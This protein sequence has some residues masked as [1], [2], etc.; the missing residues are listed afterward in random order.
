VIAKQD[1]S[2]V[3]GSV[4][5]DPGNDTLTRRQSFEQ[6]QSGLTLRLTSPITDALLSLGSQAKEAGQ[7]G[8]DRLKALNAVKMLES[9]WAMSGAAGQS[10]AALAKGDLNNAG[11]KIELSVGASKS[12]SSSEYNANTIS[13]SSLNGGGNVTV[14]AT[15]A[16]GASGDL[17]LT[18]SGITG[19]NVT[20]AAAHDLNL[21]AASN[22]SDQKSSNKSSGWS[23]GVHIAI[24]QETGIGVQAS[25]FM[26]SGSENGNTTSYV[27]SRV[28]AKDNLTLSS[29]NDTLLSGAQALGNRITVDAG[30]NL[31]LT[32]L[33]D[34]DNYQSKQ[35][36]ASGGFSFT[37]G[38]MTGSAGL[39]ISKSKVKSEY[40]SVGDQSG[41]FAG[42][43][44]YDIYVGNHTQLNGAVI[45]STAQAA[46]NHLSTG[47]LGWGSID[48]HA[49]YSASSAAMGI[50]GGYNSNNKPGEQ[51]AGSALPALVNLNG[52]ASGTTQSAI[53]AGTIT[54]R[55]ERNQKQDVADLSRDTDNANGSIGKIFDKEKVEN[56][57][58]F[59][60]GVQELAGKVVS[61][62]KAYKLDE[63]AKETSDR[64]LKE[65]PEYASLSNE[66]FN[67][68]VRNDS[69]YKDVA[70]KWGTGGTYSMVASAVAGALGGLSANNMGAAASGAMAP[71]IANAIKKATTSYNA[72]GTEKTNLVANTMAHAVAGAILAEI[73]GGDGAAGAA[74]A[75]GGELIARAIVS[76]MY[77]GVKASDLTESQ[78]QTVSA[79]S[80]LAAGLAGSLAS[81]SSAGISAGARAGKNAAENNAMGC[82]GSNEPMCIGKPDEML[83]TGGGGRGGASAVSKEISGKATR[84]P[85]M[86]PEGAGRNG[87]FREAKRQ[88]GIPVGQNPSNVY[89][90]V[91]KRGNSQPGLIYEFD[92][93]K[94]G[95]GTA[96][97]YIRDD[98][99]G[100]SFGSDNPQ[101]R[102]AH[103]NDPKG[104]H[105]DY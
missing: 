68:L 14:V 18:G 20:L 59:A 75:A 94:S 52:S 37:F 3:G 85:N 24:G 98:A 105:Y 80:Q 8:D 73:S 12:K 69:G 91:D 58:A 17:N 13:G 43:G 95:G 35:Q 27:N 92:V 51:Y 78:K 84:P 23:A 83:F 1:I 86:S 6:K 21:I 74:G 31:T 103:F 29:G 50:S 9:G 55:D 28:N 56:Q 90:N 88:A 104:N 99:G 47:T 4:T 77:P 57:M 22:N 44:G 65:H 10:A 32:S 82:M 71:Y 89:P 93:P 41:L 100:H 97:V 87:A 79:L 53:S 38:S 39:S 102:G 16:N 96:K 101:N 49:S 33:Q 72:D 67:T 7:A 42:D 62:V 54:V 2:L 26:A 34:I 40:A 46:D 48:N 25:G 11:I 15:G 61:D 60:Q 30:N 63:A 70:D 76:G 66:D 64:L 5:I 81:N 36:S 45:A 19:G